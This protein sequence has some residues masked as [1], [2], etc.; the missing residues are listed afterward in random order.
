MVDLVIKGGRI[1]SEGHVTPPAWLAVETGKIL[2]LGVG[3]DPPEAKLTIDATDKYIMPGVVDPEQHPVPPFKDKILLE[4]RASIASGVTTVGMMAPSLF[5]T[6]APD[7]VHRR[8]ELPRMKKPE[9]VPTFMEVIPKWIDMAKGRT[10]VDWFYS[11]EMSA[12]KHTKEMPELAEKLGV[13][14]FKLYLHCMAGQHI[15]DMWPVMEKQG[16]FYYDDGTVFRAMRNVAAMGPP[17][18]L[19]LHCENMEIERLFKEELIAQGRSDPEAW[20]DKSPP[21]TEAGHVRNYAYYAKIAGCP[22]YLIHCTTRETIA[23]VLRAKADGTQ[24]CAQAGPRYLTL[25][26]DKYPAL[27][28]VPIRSREE[29]EPIWEAMRKGIINTI[30]SDHVWEARALEDVEKTGILKYPHNIWET[31]EI[32]GSAVE[33]MLPIMLSEGVNKGRL[34]LERVVEIMCENTARMFGLFPKKGTIAVGSDAD[35]VIVDLNKKKKVTRDMI[36]FHAGWSIWEDWEFTG[37]PIMTIL[38]GNVMMEWPEGQPRKIVG[39]PIGQ[40]LLRKHGHALYPL[41]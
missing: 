30:G 21:F 33:A 41:D 39:K 27:I 23:E 12:E 37:W 20:S 15:W 40:Y 4:S 2:A 26:K 35:L 32:S 5:I 7:G 25:T 19:C 24:I 16:Y 18:V 11:P 29:I 13:T 28:N 17:A 6:P 36:L 22:I 14:S 10:M 9:D 34:S 3:Q 38:R 1:V 8:A 31:W